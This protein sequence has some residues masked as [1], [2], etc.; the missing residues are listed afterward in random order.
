MSDI[1]IRFIHYVLR[2]VTL[3]V[4]VNYQKQAGPRTSFK[5]SKMEIATVYYPD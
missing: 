4:G 2:G 3:W 5:P 1:E